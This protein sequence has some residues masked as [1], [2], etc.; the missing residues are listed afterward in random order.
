MATRSIRFNQSALNRLTRAPNGETGR[1][2]TKVGTQLTRESQQ[3]ARERIRSR[4]GRYLAGF[5]STT[6]ATAR[7]LRLQVT[8]SARSRDGY[9]Y[10]RGLERGTRPHIIRPRRARVLTFVAASGQRVY[11]TMVRHPGTKAYRIMET[12]MRRVMARQR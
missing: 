3:V 2:L 7:G 4:S 9:N 10:A 1:Y 5:K 12:A 6:V 11:T 8:N